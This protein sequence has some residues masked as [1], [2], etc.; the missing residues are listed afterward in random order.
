[1]KKIFLITTVFFF[2]TGCDKEV[3]KQEKKSIYGS[4]KLTSFVNQST[5]N[6]LVKSD[7]SNSN[8]ITIIFNQELNFTGSTVINDFLGNFSLEDRNGQ[9]TFLEFSTTEVNE[10]EWGNLFY[11]SLNSNYNQQTGN[12]ENPYK[13]MQENIL[14]IFYSEQ[15]YMTFEKQ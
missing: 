11:Q 8:N 15:E 12:W 2:F 5:N 3:A 6:V 9:L 14:K 7:F 1:M 4:W 13:I 10:T